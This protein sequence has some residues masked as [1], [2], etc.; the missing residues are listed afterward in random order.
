MN[1]IKDFS[2]YIN[3]SI[4][5]T[6]ATFGAAIAIKAIYSII[7]RRRLLNS[8]QKSDFSKLEK[9]VKHY[10]KVS[11]FNLFKGGIEPMLKSYIDDDSTCIISYTNAFDDVMILTLDKDNKKFKFHWQLNHTQIP[12]RI[13]TTDDIEIDLDDEEY[14][15][16]F[17]IFQQVKKIKD[18]QK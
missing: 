9:L 5:G 11:D 2:E 6:M 10:N 1:N 13:H 12:F 7:S 14:I 17:N 4:I 18:N 8:I 15:K 16:I 3:E